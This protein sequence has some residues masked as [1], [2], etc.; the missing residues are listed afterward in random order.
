MKPLSKD[1]SVGVLGG[2]QLS[3]MLCEE[4]NKLG[5]PFRAYARPK[6]EAIHT[7]CKEI[8]IGELTDTKALKP[9]LDSVDVVIFESEFVPCDILRNFSEVNFVPSISTMG[10][11]QSK[12]S[13]KELLSSLKLPTSPFNSYSE[14]EKLE[15]WV[16]K[17]EKTFNGVVY[18]WATMG[19]DGKGVKKGGDLQETIS[20]LKEALSQGRGV[21]AEKLIPFKQELA[22]I[23]CRSINGEF[24]SYPLVFS[25]QVNGVCKK[26]WGPATSLG[27]IKTLEAEANRIA[28]TIAEGANLVGSFGVEFFLT[29]D[30]ELLV[31][32]IAPRVHNTGHY[33]Q[34]ACKTSQFENHLRAVLG[35]PLGNV[36]TSECFIMVNLLGPEGIKRSDVKAPTSTKKALVHWYGKTSVA[37]GRKMG[38]IN[39]AIDSTSKL[40]EL[41]KELIKL[42]QNWRESLA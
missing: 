41:E 30:D 39:G 18:K 12:R 15:E 9:F 29:E 34:D 38:H 16:A 22:V 19:Y 14:S 42:D 2:G 21:Y 35:L 27:V 24:L 11:L 17:C 28:K 20:F 5:I 13:Q 40:Q 26:V 37:P 36:D 1:K 31:N 3:Q 8:T 10:H 4:A 23:G 7:V 33:T 6:D 25:E 32:E